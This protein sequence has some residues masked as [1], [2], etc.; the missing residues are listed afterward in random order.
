MKLVFAF[1]VAF[2]GVAIG[3]TV[4]PR[5][6]NWTDVDINSDDGKAAVDAVR[7]FLTSRGNRYGRERKHEV[8]AKSV[9]QQ[10]ID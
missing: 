9:Q 4:M 10:V 6:G 8:N 3:Q 7:E 1:F 2:I 5:R